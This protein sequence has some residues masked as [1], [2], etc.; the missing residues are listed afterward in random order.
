[1]RL[2]EDARVRGK[3]YWKV[4]PKMHKL[5]HT[6]LHAT[7]MNPRWVQNY[8]EESLIG[9]TTRVWQKAMRGRYRAHAQSNVLLRRTLGLLLRLEL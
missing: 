9:T 7:V 2:R 5:Q 8:A 4:A 3:L 1:M 6:P